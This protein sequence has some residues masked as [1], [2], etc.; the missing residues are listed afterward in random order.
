MAGRG[1]ILVVDDDP[2]FVRAHKKFLEACGGECLCF[3]DPEQAI[4]AIRV[5][6]SIVLVVTDF[7]MGF[8]D[9]AD[10]ADAAILESLPCVLIS[11]MPQQLKKFTMVFYKD[12][13]SPETYQSI[14]DLAYKGAVNG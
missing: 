11:G 12:K 13:C 5:D 6:P 14:V 1:K 4:E 9:G 7:Y 3:T 2:F 10:V 8:L